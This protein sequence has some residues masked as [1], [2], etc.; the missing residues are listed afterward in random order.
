MANIKSAKKKAKQSLVHRVVNLSRKSDLKTSY[1]KV[2]D[3]IEA[4][5]VNLAK[6]LLKE[7]ESKISRASGKGLL[8]KNTAIRKISRVAKKVADLAKTSA[9]SA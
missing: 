6:T 3:A 1:S 8:K 7:V 9:K 4:K 2:L 5:D